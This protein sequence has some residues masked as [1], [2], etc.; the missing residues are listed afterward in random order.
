MTAKKRL[1]VLLLEK[2]LAPSRQKAQALIL[3]G[4]VLVEDQPQSKPGHLVAESCSIRVRGAEHP[5]VSRG[6][7]KLSAALEAFQIHPQGFIALDVGASTGGFTQV[8]LQRGA[9]KVHAI[10]VGHNQMAWEIRS[11]PRV[12]VQEKLNARYLSFDQIGEHVDLIVIDVSF[13]S[14]EKILPSL[15]QFAQLKTHWVALVKPQFEVGKGKLGKGGVVHSNEL[16]QEALEKV[17]SF[18]K[19]LG[20]HPLGLIESPITGAEGN[21]EYLI[22]WK[23]S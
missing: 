7:V 21:V 2:G 17:K 13:I 14:L 3:S 8:L 12:V 9:K 18:A 19:N 4:H 20:L 10:D 16:R 15:L 23:L 5:Y 1:D 11:D 22:H 6:G